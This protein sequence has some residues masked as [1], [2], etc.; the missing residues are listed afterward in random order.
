MGL[1]A[2]AQSPPGIWAGNRSW[3]CAS[4]DA[5]QVDGREDPNELNTE[6]GLS[7]EYCCTVRTVGGAYGAPG[8]VRYSP[9]VR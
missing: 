3:R 6:G 7:T 4:C 1:L 5:D 8:R 2:T 9:L